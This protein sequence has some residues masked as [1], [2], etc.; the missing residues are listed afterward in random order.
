MIKK[1]IYGYSFMIQNQYMHIRKDSKVKRTAL[2]L[3]CWLMTI[4]HWQHNLFSLDIYKINQRYQ[5]LW[6]VEVYF[7]YSA[8]IWFIINHSPEM[9]LLCD[10]SLRHALHT[11]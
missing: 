11:I 3:F 4:R 9:L 1:K 7:S 10:V 6:R 2:L 5:K 8:G